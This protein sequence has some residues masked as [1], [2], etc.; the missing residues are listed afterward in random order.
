[1]NPKCEHGKK[2]H[3]FQ[4]IDHNTIVHPV[5]VAPVEIH[6]CGKYESSELNHV[7]GTGT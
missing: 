7:G 4:N 1:M 3:N 2:D 6:N 5:C